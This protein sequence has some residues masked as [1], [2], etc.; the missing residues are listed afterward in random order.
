VQS[1]QERGVPDILVYHNKMDPP[2]KARP[3]A[4]RDRQTAQLDALEEFLEH[5]TRQGEILKG[6]LTT[7]TD[8]AQFEEFFTE[9]LRKL[10]K[11]RHPKENRS[12]EP[13]LPRASWTAGSPFRGLE[14]FEFEHVPIFRGRTRAVQEVI[15]LLRRQHVAHQI[16][17]VDPVDRYAPPIFVLVSAMSG[18][19]KSSLVR[20][21]VLPLVTTPGVIEGIRLW[22]HAIIKPTGGSGGLFDALGTALSAKGAS[23]E[24][25]ADGTPVTRLVQL[26]RTN[27][28]G[29]EPLVKGGLSQAAAELQAEDEAQL[30]KWEEEFSAQG[31]TA[32]SNRCRNQREALKQHGAALVLF[33]DQLEEIFTATDNAAE[34][35]RDGFVIAID[36]LA[37]SGRVM[38]VA[39]LRSDFFA[40]ATENPLLAGLIREGALYQLQTPTAVELAQMI[41]EPAREAGLRFDED[42]ETGSRLDDILLAATQNDPAALPLLEFTLEQLYQ[43]R[44]PD[45]CLTHKVYRELNGIE[46]A[47]AQRA[48]EEFAELGPDSKAAFGR[49]FGALVNLTEVRSEERP[50][51][52]RATIS[53]FESQ[54]G[55]VEFVDRFARARLLVLSD[56]GAGN[57]SVFVVHEA[58]FSHWDRLRNWIEDNRDL[59][60]V[61]T[62]VELAAARWNGEGQPRDLLLP[63]GRVLAVRVTFY[64][65]ADR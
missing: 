18:I 62:R 46:G 22:R 34:A 29:A 28:S 26:L 9:H 45:G 8:L 37:R 41:R 1:F 3:K 44:D 40:R 19:G 27:P 39:T 47:L 12:T 52:R 54:P 53:Q 23:E 7:Y 49:V 38:V 50:V 15:G 6:A 20:A 64:L 65:S 51:R 11:A 55:A 24:L 58:L 42:K 33:V 31:R 21:G 48:E 13:A 61:R 57:R 63:D 30:R 16:W 32:D 59:L 60:R 43:R 5:W 4:E 14:P 36:A 25:L 2:I 17:A 35:E 56:D 10:V